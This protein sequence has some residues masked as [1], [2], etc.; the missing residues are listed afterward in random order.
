MPAGLHKTQDNNKIIIALK[1]QKLF[2]TTSIVD[3]PGPLD[4]KIKCCLIK[5]V[6]II[7]IIIV[8]IIGNYEAIA[9]FNCNMNEH[10]MT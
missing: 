6:L 9:E 4:E 7:I 8:Y 3:S 5:Q 1:N 2:E 10:M